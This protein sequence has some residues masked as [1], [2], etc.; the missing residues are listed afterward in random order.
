MIGDCDSEDR[1]G[2]L[3][4][5]FNSVLIVLSL[6]LFFVFIVLSLLG[7]LFLY[8]SFLFFVLLFALEWD[9]RLSLLFRKSLN[10][11]LD[12]QFNCGF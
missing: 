5:Y 7:F 8:Y 6:F 3:V 2:T 1:P 11:K 10:I 9:L 12:G 4:L